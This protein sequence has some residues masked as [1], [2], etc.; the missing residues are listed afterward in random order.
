M[1]AAFRIEDFDGIVAQCCDEDAMLAGTRG[2]MIDAA[3][4]SRHRNRCHQ[5]QRGLGGGRGRHDEESSDAV[6][7]RHVWNKLLEGDMPIIRRS[8]GD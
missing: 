6:Q 3:L 7:L 8:S 4:H 5:L 2:E 1:L